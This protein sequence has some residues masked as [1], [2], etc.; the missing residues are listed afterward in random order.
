MNKAMAGRRTLHTKALV[1]DTT[2]LAEQDLILTLLG[3]SGAQLRAVAKG[4]RKPG[5]RLA[6]RSELFCESDFLIAE[7]RKL[8][9]VSEASVVD[10]H[11]ALRGDLSRVSAAS[12]VCELARLTCF[13]DA[14]DAFLFPLCSRTLRACEE[15]SD[16]S[17]LLLVVAAYAF[18][19][20]A[21]S[22]WR[23][24]LDACV[25]CGDQHI[26]WFSSSLGGV[27]CQSCVRDVAGAQP[28]IEGEAAWLRVLL[29]STFDQLLAVQVTER[30][31]KRLVFLAHDWAVTQLDSR[32]RAWEFMADM[33]VS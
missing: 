3:E 28:L 19:L 30:V 33:E 23:P 20:L 22:G 13:E 1:L 29:Y 11:A 8:G 14:T 6:A 15:A 18:K 27:V 17:H 16:P 31:A 5:G 9:I 7:G 32:L 26:S 21:H 12:S 10:A 4:A 2:K 25:G 24:E